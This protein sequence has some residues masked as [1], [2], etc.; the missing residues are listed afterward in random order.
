MLCCINV[1]ETPILDTNKVIMVNSY[2][3]GI[4]KQRLHVSKNAEMALDKAHVEIEE[5]NEIMEAA[6]ILCMLK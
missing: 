5:K 1:F 3:L 2:Y 6:G 4:V